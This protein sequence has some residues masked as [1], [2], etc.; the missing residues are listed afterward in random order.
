MIIQRCISQWFPKQ[1]QPIW[2]NLAASQV[3]TTITKPT[4]PIWKKTSSL[5]ELQ[6]KYQLDTIDLKI[7]W[8]PCRVATTNTKLAHTG[9]LTKNHKINLDQEWHYFPMPFVDLTIPKLQCHRLW[10]LHSYY[11]NVLH[12]VTFAYFRVPIVV[13]TSLWI[14]NLSLLWQAPLSTLGILLPTHQSWAWE[15]GLATN[16][17]GGRSPW[18]MGVRAKFSNES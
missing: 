8:Q 13:F 18:N 12:V 9:R 15:W 16:Q 5:L 7:I 11:Y 2:R 10:I 14:S 17:K 1:T 3:V 4:Q 6:T